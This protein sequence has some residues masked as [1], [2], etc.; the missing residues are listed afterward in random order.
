MIKWRLWY[1][2]KSFVVQ[3]P[4]ETLAAFEGFTKIGEWPESAHRVYPSI[5]NYV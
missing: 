1:R 5:K 4:D 2:N 3:A